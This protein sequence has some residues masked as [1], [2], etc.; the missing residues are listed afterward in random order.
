M[1][2][3]DATGRT[4]SGEVAELT[5]GRRKGNEPEG[6]AWLFEEIRR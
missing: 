5:A 6:E 3:F 2:L 1:N 4:P